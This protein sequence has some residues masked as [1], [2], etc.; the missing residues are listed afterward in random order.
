[1]RLAWLLLGISHQVWAPLYVAWLSWNTVFPTVAIKDI[2]H[3]VWAPLYVAWLSWNTVFHT[4]A[5]KDITHQV[6]VPLYIAWLSCKYQT[7]AINL[8]TM[9]FAYVDTHKNPIEIH[10]T[11][12]GKKEIYSIFKTSCIISV[13]FPTKCHLFHNFIFFIHM[14]FTNHVLKFKYQPGCLKVKDIIHQVWTP[15]YIT[16]LS[17]NISHCSY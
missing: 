3:Q 6:W 4:V 9:Y 10:F 14:F 1:M 11:Y 12:L 13:L 16:W 17:W 15:L 5:I 2:T 7:V 8:Y